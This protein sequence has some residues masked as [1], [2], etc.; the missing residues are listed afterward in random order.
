M[1]E[2][3]MQS[4]LSSKQDK[5]IKFND[6]RKLLLNLNFKERIKGDHFIYKRDD[7]PERVNI[8]PDGDMSKSYQVRQ[9]RGI[10]RK[11]RLGDEQYD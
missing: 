3:I 7:L 2:K 11:Y 8:Q 1:N 6:L 10:I 4:V 9:I 5:N